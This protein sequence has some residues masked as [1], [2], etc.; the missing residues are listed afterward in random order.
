MSPEPHP[1]VAILAADAG[2]QVEPAR[3]APLAAEHADQR[4]RA[5]RLRPLLT[6]ADE[7]GPLDLRP[8]A[9]EAGA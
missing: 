6:P 9:A 8:L 7:P 4:A 2:L 3:L 5:D 1:A